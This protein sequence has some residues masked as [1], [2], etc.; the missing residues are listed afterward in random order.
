MYCVDNVYTVFCVMSHNNN[1]VLLDVIRKIYTLVIVYIVELIYTIDP[2][3]PSQPCALSW[4]IHAS[5]HEILLNVNTLRMFIY[6]KALSYKWELPLLNNDSAAYDGNVHLY[7]LCSNMY[8]C[9]LRAKFM[10]NSKLMPVSTLMHNFIMSNI[11][12]ELTAK[13]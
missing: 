8:K 10:G 9:W 1:W 12:H 5:P 3:P 2:G 11:V 7:K 4:E 13:M 6:C